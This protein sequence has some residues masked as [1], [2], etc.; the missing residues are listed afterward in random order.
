MQGIHSGVVSTA[1]VSGEQ[2][3]AQVAEQIVSLLLASQLNLKAFVFSTFIPGA[4]GARME[5]VLGG[6]GGGPHLSSLLGPTQTRPPCRGDGLLQERWRSS[7]PVPQ[8]VLHCPHDDHGVQPPFLRRQ[9]TSAAACRPTCC[10]GVCREAANAQSDKNTHFF[11]QSVFFSSQVHT[12][13]YLIAP[14]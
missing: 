13:H 7:K 9:A 10:V 3:Q 8:V 14:F 6:G 4:P 5:V 12:S 11:C 2:E 1:T